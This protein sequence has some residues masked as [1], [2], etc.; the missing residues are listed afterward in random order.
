MLVVSRKKARMIASSRKICKLH[1]RV[2]HSRESLG[3]VVV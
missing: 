1:N 3:S 2:Q